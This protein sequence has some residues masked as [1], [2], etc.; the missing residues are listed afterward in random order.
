MMIFY[1]VSRDNPAAPKKRQAQHTNEKHQD[2]N[3]K[4]PNV[5]N[6][7]TKG[8]HLSQNVPLAKL[9][10]AKPWLA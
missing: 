10:W 2:A 7:L 4:W 8:Q 1:G 9:W 3:A 6:A 5:H